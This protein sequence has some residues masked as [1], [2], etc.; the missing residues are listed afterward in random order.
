[1]DLMNRV[2]RPYL[3]KF[4]IVFIDNILIYSKTRE[5]HVEHLRL[6][7]G[8]LK[9]EK[10]HAKF[11]ECEF[12]LREVQFLGHVINGNEI[13]VDPSKIEA[14]KNWK[15]PKTLIE[16]RSLLGLA[17]YYCR[18]I[19]NI[20]KIAKSLTILTRKCK[21]F[22][23]GEEQEL[24]F[25]TLK[26]KFVLA[27]PDGPED[28][29]VY[30]DASGIGLGCVLMQRGKVIDCAS[31][32]LKI[33]KNNYT[34]R[35]LE[36]AV[37]VQKE[38]NMRQ[39]RWIELFSDYNCEIRYQPGKVNV[40]ADALSRKEIVKPKR[41][42]AMN[43]ILRS[44]IKDRILAAQ[45][46][47][48]DMKTLIMDEAYKSK[49]Y[50][51]PGVD[52]M[53]YDLRDMYWWPRMKKDIAE[54][55]RIAMDFMT[56]LPRTSSGHDTIWVIM[57][58][59]TKSAQFLPMREDYKIDRLARLYLNEI[60]AR[61]G[62]SILIISDRDSRFTSRFWQSMQEALGTRL[63]ISTA[64]H[65]QTDG[66]SERTIQ[67]LEDMLKVCV[68]DF[69][70][71]WDVHLPL[72]EVGEGQLIGPEL[73]Q[74]TT[75]KISQIKDRLKAARDRQKS[76]A[77]KRRKPVEFSVGDCVLLKV[78]PWK[79]VVRLGKKRKLAPIFVG[80]FEIIEKMDKIDD[81][82]FSL[83]NE[84][85]DAAT[86]LRIS[87]EH[88]DSTSHLASGWEDPKVKDMS[89]ASLKP[90]SFV[91]ALHM[92][93]K[94][95]K[96]NFRSL[97]NEEKV[98]DVDF[99]LPKENVEIAHNRFA[100]S[101]V[102]FFVGE[103]GCM[104]RNQPLIL[105]K[106][107]P[108]LDLSKDAV[109]KVP[110]W[111]KIHKVPVVA[112]SPD[113]LSLIASQIGKPVMLDAFTSAMCTEPWGRIGYA[114]ACTLIE[115]SADKELKKEVTMVVSLL[116]GEG[117]VKEKM[118]VDYD[119]KPPRCSEC[120]VFG[121]DTHDCPKCIVEPAKEAIDQTDGFTTVR[122][123]KNKGKKVANETN[124]HIEGLTLS[125]PK[126][127]YALSV[128]SNQNKDKASK[129]VQDDSN[130]VPL[131]NNFTTLQDDDTFDY[132]ADPNLYASTSN[133]NGVESEV[134]EIDN[135][136]NVKDRNGK[137]ASTPFDEVLN[138]LFCTFVYAGNKPMERRLLWADLGLH[139]HAVRGVPWV[140]LGDFNVAL[141]MEDSFASSSSMDSAM[142]C[143]V[144]KKLDHVMGNMNFFNTFLGSYAVFKPYR[145]SDHSPYVLNIPSLPAAKPK[146]FK[147]YNFLAHKERFKDVVADRWGCHVE[148]YNMYKVVSKLKALKKQLCKLLHD[149]GNLHDHV[150]RL[151]SELDEVQKSLD[152]DSS[153]PILREEEAVYVQ[154]FS[155]AKLDEE[156]FLR[157]KAKV[158]WLEVGDSNSAYFHKSIK[159]RNQRSRIDLITTAN[160]VKVFGNMVPRVFVSHYKDFLGSSMPC[161]E[162]NID[163]LFEKR[164]SDLSNQNM[165]C[166]V[167]NEEIK[168]AM[169]SICDNKAPSPD[170]FTFVFFKKGWDVVGQDVCNGVRDFFVNGK[171][172]KEINHTFLALIPKVSTPHKVN[173]F[174][175]ISCCNVIYKCISKILTNR[176]IEGV[177]EV[178][179]ENQSAFV[180]GRRISDNI[181]LTQELMHNYHL[182]HGHPRCAFKVDIQKAYD[183]VDWCFLDRILTCFGFHPN[184]VKWVMACV[185]SDSFS[186]CI[187][188]EVHG[189]FN[190]KWGLR[191]GDPLS[192]YLFTLVM[193]ILTL[194]LK[195]RVRFSDHFQ[196]HKYCEE[197]SIIN[198]CFADDLFLFAR[199]GVESAKVIM[200]SLK[201]FKAVSGL[202]PSI[203]KSTAYFCNVLNHVKIS[204]LNIMPFFE[205]KLPV[206]YLGV[207]LISSRLLNKDCKI[208]VERV[209][210]K[211]GDWKNKSLSFAGRLQLC[212]SVLASM[213]V[214]WASVLV[215]PKGI[216]HDIQ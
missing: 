149:Q 26:D 158:E 21:T 146:P 18:F 1:M 194:M 92:E 180:P 23:W 165:V 144:L 78:L 117:H 204:I 197:L 57:D 206:K 186:L 214:F 105:T 166:L 135:E 118:I 52:K 50:V 35:D 107:A 160:N 143:G 54:Y 55:V 93:N 53:Y 168:H 133:V 86:T 77:N 5:E 159:C 28:F 129:S 70:G 30:C 124:K 63:E 19:E 109:T 130:V 45:K 213:Q 102:G 29:V 95:P 68:L 11:S 183:T 7:L 15:A 200:D 120:K 207:P 75:E 141:N 140:L 157:Q 169:F 193:E 36:L 27:L 74:E 176:L 12:W 202:V 81:V 203:P 85:N 94:N 112:Y 4:V 195:R 119:W 191:Q 59:F 151:R 98:D 82:V 83:N 71:S 216:V 185:T 34:T 90:K 58:L 79:G 100:N 153:N 156:R 125:R 69:E 14:V 163:G 128:K 184:M 201:E 108:N 177:K 113:G 9:K 47:A 66:Q 199:G 37:V 16:V 152:R 31:R 3:D 210:N 8:L 42:R 162:V 208:L 215:L 61:H 38:L 22:D 13:H 62:V 33:H 67:T 43:M 134:E 41:V 99:V 205:G 212:T 88:A 179:S 17:G 137:R 24:A 174:R 97:F 40:V 161:D 187:N 182:D 25:Q 147:F 56:K 64:Y 46:E 188:G 170:G 49:Y 171:L 122:T 115:V 111:V 80:P 72:A 198:V 155:E 154:A 145:I 10:L 114:R 136:F 96:V 190:G 139:K 65:P 209:L 196:Y 123:R 121:H 48:G 172:L 32:Q 175:P 116:N 150:N 73:V 103:K 104:I 167:T 127:K 39:L 2:C 138:I 189:F 173:D 6:V 20:S 89:N 148:G 110:I 87:T 101:L 51:H 181:L 126:P 106:W 164:V 192:P 84:L 60:V 211:I 131:K 178:M 91:N 76:Y 142:A 44:S 132:N